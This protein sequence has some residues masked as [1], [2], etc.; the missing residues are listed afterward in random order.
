MNK[1]E[2]RDTILNRDLNINSYNMKD[3]Y[4]FSS[5]LK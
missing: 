3:A 2:I 5:L 1:N 4:E